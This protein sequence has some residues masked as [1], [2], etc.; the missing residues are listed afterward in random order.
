MMAANVFGK[1]MM[2]QNDEELE[3]AFRSREF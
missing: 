3:S 2:G 1:M